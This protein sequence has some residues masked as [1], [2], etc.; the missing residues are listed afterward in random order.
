MPSTTTAPDTVLI[1]FADRSTR[2][3]PTHLATRIVGL[4][5]DGHLVIPLA[6]PDEDPI[7]HGDGTEYLIPLT[8]CCHATGKGGEHGVICRGCHQPVDEKFGGPT[9]VAVLVRAD[10][11]AA[12]Q[13]LAEIG[14]P[15]R[16]TAAQ[17]DVLSLL[18]DQA[19]KAEVAQVITDSH[20]V[21]WL[22]GRGWTPAEIRKILREAGVL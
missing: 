4:D 7:R 3:V 18:V 17:T 16:I 1:P 15:H 20:Q 22:I 13:I 19:A 21:A 6:G 11:A 10:V 2:Q 8:S 12:R 14:I 5:R 9:R